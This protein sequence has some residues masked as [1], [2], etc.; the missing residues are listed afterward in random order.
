M[1]RLGWCL[2][3]NNL[4]QASPNPRLRN[5]TGDGHQTANRPIHDTQAFRPSTLSHKVPNH[6]IDPRETNR[7]GLTELCKRYVIKDIGDLVT[8]AA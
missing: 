6:T 5:I 8:V 4:A 1:A 7:G 3:N 2:S